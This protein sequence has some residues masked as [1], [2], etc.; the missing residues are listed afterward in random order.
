MSE[1]LDR[2]KDIGTRKICEDT[3][4]PIGYIQAILYESFDGLNKIQFIGFISILEREYGEDLS[5]IRSRGIDYFDEKNAPDTTI[6]SGIIFKSSNNKMF[7]SIFYIVLAIIFFIIAISFSMCSSN[8]IPDNVTKENKIIEDARRN[9]IADANISESNNSD[10]NVSS[11]G[12]KKSI[13]T[14]VKEEKAPPQSLKITARK[15]VWL[16]YTDVATNKKYQKIF[17]GELELDPAKE[18][19][20]YFGHSYID[21]A[22]NGEEIKYN[23]GKTLR[24]H[25]KNSNIEQISI[26]EFKRLN[27]GHR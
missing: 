1:A 14:S 13:A 22:I 15:E 4:I 23:K 27:R 12:D 11:I 17:K 8:D 7:F 26:N 24:L 9:I 20:L 18:W 6:A 25:Y 21:V 3:H 5:A 19:L 2:L 16:G 10:K